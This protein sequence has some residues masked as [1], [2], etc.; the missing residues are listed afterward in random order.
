MTNTQMPKFPDI[1]ACDAMLEE[2]YLFV[3]EKWS[4]RNHNNSIWDLRAKWSTV[5]PQLQ[6]QLLSGHYQLSP[7]QS[8]YTQVLGCIKKGFYFLGV[9]FG[10]EPKMSK[11]SLENH[12][13]KIAQRYA[14]GASAACIGDYIE[15]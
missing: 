12:R 14:Q 5:K 9:H 3:S 13:S 11:T 15:R 1:A 10:D 6:R 4:E 7:L 2:A 8:H